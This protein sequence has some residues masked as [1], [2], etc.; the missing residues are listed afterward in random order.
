V[1]AVRQWARHLCSAVA[2]CLPLLA[3]AQTS[4]TTTLTTSGTPSVYGTAITLTATVTGSSTPTGTVSFKNGATTLLVKTLAGTT[5]YDGVG[6]LAQTSPPANTGSMTPTVIDYGYDL[7]DAL[8]SVALGRSDG[9][10][11]GARIQKNTSFQ[12]VA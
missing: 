12:Y 4:T 2:V 7:Q 3:A 11:L 10:Y 9:L 6:L 5:T 1:S 8:I